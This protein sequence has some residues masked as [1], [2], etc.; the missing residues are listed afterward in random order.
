M[1]RRTLQ[2]LQVIVGYRPNSPVRVSTGMC[3]QAVYST[4]YTNYAG[5]VPYS[6][7]KWGITQ[8]QEVETGNGWYS[9]A[10][11]PASRSWFADLVCSRQSL[12]HSG[13]GERRGGREREMGDPASGTAGRTSKKERNKR[14]S[15][16]RSAQDRKQAMP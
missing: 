13:Y 9:M 10:E 7:S 1:L 15:K 16:R 6:S 4:V 12:Y 3:G 14:Y 5:I 2:V 11:R 8:T